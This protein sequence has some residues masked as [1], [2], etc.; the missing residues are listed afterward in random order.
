MKMLI[1]E[2]WVGKEEKIDVLNPYN[3]N[4]VDTVPSGDKDD[5]EAAFQNMGN[6]L[7]TKFFE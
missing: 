2:K 6:L 1:G 7:T 4:L 3:N 5:V